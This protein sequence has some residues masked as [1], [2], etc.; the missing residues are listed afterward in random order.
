MD[1][2]MKLSQWSFIIGCSPLCFTTAIA[3]DYRNLK[4]EL[5]VLLYKGSNHSHKILTLVGN[6]IDVYIEFSVLD[7]LRYG[8]M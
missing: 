4:W 5:P 7:S 2:K 8:I 3:N 6:V 1:L